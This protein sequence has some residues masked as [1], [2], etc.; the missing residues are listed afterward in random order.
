VAAEHLHHEV[1]LTVPSAWPEVARGGPAMAA[2]GN[3]ESGSGG[4]V[5]RW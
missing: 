2:A 4:N 5:L 1:H 3:D